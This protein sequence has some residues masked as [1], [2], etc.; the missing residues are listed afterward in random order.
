MK[1]ILFLFAIAM[2]SLHSVSQ[3]MPA[4]RLYN[5]KGK[6]VDYDKLVKEAS[7]ADIVLFGEQHNNPIC[8]W[9]QIELTKSLYQLKKK[10][11]VMGA[12][13][14]EADNALI[15]S[16]YLSGK[17]K[18]KNF[19]AEA[20]LWPNYKTDYKPLLM[21]A[22]DSN[23][24]FVATNIPRR[25]ASLVNREGFEALELLDAEAKRYIAPLPIAYDPELPGYKGMLEMMGGSG[26]HA[27]D[28]LPRAQAVK[29]A[30][31]AYFIAGNSGDG[32]TFIHFHGT[33]H[34]DN[35]EGIVW[36]LKNLKP[37]LKIL[38]ISS[39]EQD[40]VDKLDEENEKKADF[41]LVIP[42]SMTKTN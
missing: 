26:N 16:E 7:E 23:L 11:L 25:Y 14:F 27:T 1:K 6:T 19:E 3:D 28:N 13:M 29:D 35:F 21:F 12:E 33:Y 31:M 41:I 37:D 40:N 17:I 4:Y 15:I 9:L 24:V 2:I 30:T 34:S 42:A 39:C 5:V 22:R 32:R 18:D 36:Y 20:R 8:H 10:N 38:T